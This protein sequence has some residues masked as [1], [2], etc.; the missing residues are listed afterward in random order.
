MVGVISGVISFP[1]YVVLYNVG[2]IS[3]MHFNCTFAY[4]KFRLILYIFF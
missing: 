4:L 2:T 3:D 1:I